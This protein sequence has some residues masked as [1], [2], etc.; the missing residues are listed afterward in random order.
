MKCP[1][2]DNEEVEDGGGWRGKEYLVKRD[3]E[4]V[5][6]GKVSVTEGD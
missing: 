6:E 2:G 5:E 3:V 1:V 4:D